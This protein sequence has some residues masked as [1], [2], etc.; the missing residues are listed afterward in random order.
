MKMGYRMTKIADLPVL[1]QDERDDA[2][3]RAKDLGWAALVRLFEEHVVTEKLSYQTLGNRIKRSRSHVQRWLGSPFNLSLGSLGLIA[4]GLNADL[5]ITL[6]PRTAAQRGRNYCHPSEAAAGILIAR[7]V[8]PVATTT[9][10][11]FSS[12]E[13][14]ARTS[15]REND[16]LVFEA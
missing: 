15:F 7:N 16:L 8:P 3:M 2:S 11:T 9:S 14:A 6:R 13:S 10:T 12:S 4:E 5:M 1:T